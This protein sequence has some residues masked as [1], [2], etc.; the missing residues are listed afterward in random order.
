[1]KYSNS[2]DANDKAQIRVLDCTCVSP[3]CSEL[4]GKHLKK[5]TRRHEGKFDRHEGPGCFESDCVTSPARH[6]NPVVLL[7]F[8]PSS[9]VADLSE[10][11]R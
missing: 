11:A 5:S 3:D 7:S 4:N 6:D 10:R 2:H 1:M 8:L 9:G